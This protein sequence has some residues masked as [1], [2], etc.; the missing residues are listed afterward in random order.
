MFL[1]EFSLIVTV[2][3]V[4]LLQ[5]MLINN[6]IDMYHEETN[7]PALARTSS[8]VEEL[9]QI[10][11]IFS[12]KTGTLTCNQM[13]FRMSSIAGKVSIPSPSNEFTLQMYTFIQSE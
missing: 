2:E 7:T 12:D 1:S 5:S 8:L 3:L 9:G 13:E 6:D 4:R 11:Y 10:S